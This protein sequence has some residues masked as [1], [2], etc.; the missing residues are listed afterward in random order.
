M[1]I[2]HK[3]SDS[4]IWAIIMF[5]FNKTSLTLNC[6]AKL[7]AFSFSSML[8]LFPFSPY[9]VFKLYF[10]TVQLILIVVKIQYWMSN[11][12]QTTLLALHS[13]YE[14]K[15]PIHLR[16]Y[17][18]VHAK[19]ESFCR[20]GA[21]MLIW[22]HYIPFIEEIDHSIMRSW[23]ECTLILYLGNQSELRILNLFRW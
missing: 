14:D 7:L 12:N 20:G 23:L 16:W 15:I 6:G 3:T 2:V 5:F 18:T 9:F 22:L 4:L 21:R 19:V 13:Q 1:I 10:I 17:Q 11:I 8:F